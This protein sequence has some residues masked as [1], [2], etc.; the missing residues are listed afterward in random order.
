MH[1]DNSFDKVMHS[2]LYIFL[3][4]SKEVKIAF[5]NAKLLPGYSFIEQLYKITGKSKQTITDWQH[6]LNWYWNFFSH[7]EKYAKFK[8]ETI[9]TI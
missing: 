6:M 4:A 5:Q 2:N 9:Y 1:D 7:V 3:I 8:E